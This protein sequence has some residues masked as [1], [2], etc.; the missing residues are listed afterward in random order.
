MNQM[1]S[2]PGHVGSSLWL[3]N[4]VHGLAGITIKAK[5]SVFCDSSRFQKIEVF[6]TYSYGMV[7]CLGGSIVLTEHDCDI[8]HEMMVHPA[9]LSHKKPLSVC[10]IGG[11]DGGCLSEVLKYSCVKSVSV[12][13]IDTMVK[14]TI[15]R[16]FP[17]LAKGFN[18]KRVTVT[19][20]DGYEYLKSTPDRFDIIL[21][22]SYDPAG[23]VQ[24]LETADFHNVVAERLNPD[25]I[26]VFQTDSPIV[27]PDYLRQ[28]MNL[29]SP[30]FA[31]TK[32]YICSLSSFPEGICSFLLCGREKGS[33][34]RFDAER[35]KAIEDSCSYY[36][37]DIHVGAFL[38]PQ[39]LRKK[40]QERKK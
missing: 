22:D 30:L 39:Y 4:L 9:L 6:D 23:P 24:S 14:T 37:N 28:T 16:F 10:I 34:D 26:I 1:V 12:I 7:L 38:L 40:V 5:H 33:L 31:H 8:Y 25:G 35:Y 13:D 32:P 21:V 36:N 15:E 2:Y 29:L 27:R 3:Q 17:A 18:D 11:G 20:D 19:I